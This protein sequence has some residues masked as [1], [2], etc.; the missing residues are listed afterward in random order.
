[1]PERHSPLRPSCK[2]GHK[3]TVSNTQWVL[4]PTAGKYYARCIRC[5]SLAEKRRYKAMILAKPR[6]P[7]T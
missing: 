5:K 4:H 6:S 1:M 7:T 3:M 2:K